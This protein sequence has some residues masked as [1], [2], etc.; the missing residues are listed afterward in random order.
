M[1]I[2]NWITVFRMLSVPLF[3][4]L[5]LYVRLDAALLVF[6][7]AVVSDGV[8]GFMAR[9]RHEKTRL[10]AIL[11]PVADK[12]LIVS[13]FV[14]LIFVKGLPAEFR[15]PPYVPILVISRDAI[16]LIGSA[17][18]YVIRG[19]IEVRPTTLGKATTFL[20]MMTVVSV[21]VQWRH[22]PMLWNVMSGFTVLSGVDYVL[23]GAKLLSEKK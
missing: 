6:A 11:D 18:I 1:N 16:L 17:L 21:L 2:A 3:V 9:V 7:A 4:S 10:G 19:D 22:A 23:R 14:C 15:P 12:L 20:Q 8:D 5:I 13:A